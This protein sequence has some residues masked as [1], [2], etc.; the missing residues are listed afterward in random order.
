MVL[1]NLNSFR[2]RIEKDIYDKSP[3]VEK[4]SVPSANPIT[5]RLTEAV[6][7]RTHGK[8]KNANA[9]RKVFREILNRNKITGTPEQMTLFEKNFFDTW[10][11][12]LPPGQKIRD[13]V[14]QY[15]NNPE[16]TLIP[17]FHR[18]YLH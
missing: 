5:E 9:Y 7:G 16:K 3:R 6:A 13:V 8:T 11:N 2:Q 15:I 4:Q 10:V 12:S 17:L 1:P 18:F 14:M